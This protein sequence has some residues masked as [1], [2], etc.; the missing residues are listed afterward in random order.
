MPIYEYRCETCG[1]VVESMQKMSDPPLQNCGALCSHPGDGGGQLRRILSAH[2]VGTA[3]PFGGGASFSGGS[4]GV[5]CGS[6][7]KPGPGCS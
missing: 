3:S 1:D 6:C 7:G 2:S 5:S 4:G